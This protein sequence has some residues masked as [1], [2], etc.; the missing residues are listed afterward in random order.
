MDTGHPDLAGRIAGSES[1]VPDETVQGGFGHGTHV[2]STIVGSGAASNG[3]FKGVAP[4][5]R[6]L[7]GR[8]LDNTGHGQASWI[9]AGMEWAAHSGAK[10]VSMSLGGTAYG[11]SR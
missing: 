3:R 7:V 9:I 11:P 10:I 4:G 8:V 6:L 5:A 1:F 2:A